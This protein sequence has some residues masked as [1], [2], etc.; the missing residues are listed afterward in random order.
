[1]IFD[2]EEINLIFRGKDQILCI[3]QSARP[4]IISYFDQLPVP[5]GLGD[6]V[7]TFFIVSEVDAEGDAR[8]TRTERCA[9][10]FDSFLVS[11]NIGKFHE[12]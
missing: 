6:E 5:S 7:H 11:T 4:R 3:F 2:L 9:Q 1:M 10:Q 8:V 12:I